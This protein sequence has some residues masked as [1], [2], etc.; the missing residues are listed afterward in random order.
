MFE[1]EKFISSDRLYI[2]E[3]DRKKM[4]TCVCV[5]MQQQVCYM[6]VT[7]NSISKIILWKIILGVID[8]SE[9]VLWR[10]CLGFLSATLFACKF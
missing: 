9:K 1:T 3:A 7:N 5:V 8:C 10:F 4:W 2:N 6:N